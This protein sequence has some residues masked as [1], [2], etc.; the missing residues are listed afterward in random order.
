MKLIGNCLLLLV[1]LSGS[2]IFCLAQGSSGGGV[3]NKEKVLVIKAARLFD[4][5]SERT[6]SPGV[7]IVSGGRIL[8]VGPNAV[9][10]AGAEVIDLGDATL[11]PGFMD[12]HTHL[13]GEASDDWKQDELDDLKKSPA[14]RA[15]DATVNARKTLMIGFTTVRD[16]GS[17]DFV[18]VG[19]RNAIANGKVIG[20]RMI[21]AVR[22]IGATGGHCDPT[23]GYR[24]D[25]F[26][27]GSGIDAAVANGPDAVRSAVRLNIKD[28]ANVIKVCAT[29]GVLSQ[30]DDVRS[31][32]LTQAELDALVDEAH[33]RGRK[34]AAHAHGAEGAKR[35]IRAGIDSIEHGSFL[36]DE[37]L[38]LMKAK[39][40]YLVATL[41]APEGLRERLE[42]GSYF[43][44]AVEAKARQAIASIRA[45]FR[46]AVTK[47]VRIAF[48]TDAAVYPHG[49]NAEEFRH[50]VELG[51]RPVDALKAATS[52]NAEL[53]GISDRLGTL[54]PGKLADIIAVPGDP[55]QDIR[56]TERVFFVMKEGVTYKNERK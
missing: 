39:G 8:A 27:R 3:E 24:P 46:K 34:A 36:D 9:I 14:E 40:T 19:L 41:M 22:G 49:R 35:A 25:V 23:V 52:V 20:P 44:P 47:R 11:L 56:Q 15:L 13:S 10:P 17:S 4:G 48:G 2:I 16:V 53:F 28:G 42:R 50:M 51:M 26:D 31:P 43:P 29:G 32:Q 38:D 30:N 33:A 37:A 18:D 7:V 55:T 5:K 54:E 6:I 45:M 12:A 1:L 21:V